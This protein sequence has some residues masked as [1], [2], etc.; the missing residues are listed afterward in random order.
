MPLYSSVLFLHLIHGRTKSSAVLYL[1]RDGD[2]L[3]TNKDSVHTRRRRTTKTR[4]ID[5]LYTLDNSNSNTNTS[6]AL[7]H[8]GRIPTDNKITV[9]RLMTVSTTRRSSAAQE[10]AKRRQIVPGA[11][12]RNKSVWIVPVNH[13]IKARLRT[14]TTTSTSTTAANGCYISIIWILVNNSGRNTL[15]NCRTLVDLKRIEQEQQLQQEGRR[16]TD[17][18]TRKKSI[19]SFY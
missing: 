11:A 7:R 10:Q 12:T 19:N 1:H 18:K 5:N 6:R 4:K 15:S 2:G 16:Y 13:R 14:T 17:C 8:H 3:Q 9:V